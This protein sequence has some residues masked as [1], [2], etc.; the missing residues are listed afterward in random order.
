M[1]T[2][3]RKNTSHLEINEILHPPKGKHWQLAFE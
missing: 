1:K 3:H 2:G